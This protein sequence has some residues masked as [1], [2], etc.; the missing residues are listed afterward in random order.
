[1]RWSDPG[2]VGAASQKRSNDMVEGD[3]RMKEDDIILEINGVKG[4]DN[5]MDTWPEGREL[6]ELMLFDDYMIT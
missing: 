3:Q 5:A 4:D 6:P 2:P 1:M